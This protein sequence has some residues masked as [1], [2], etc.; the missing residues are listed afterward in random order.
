MNRLTHVIEM[1]DMNIMSVRTFSPE[2][3]QDAQNLFKKIVKENKELAKYDKSYDCGTCCVQIVTGT[4]G[5]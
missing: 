4:W 2:H 3:V 5:V 1:D